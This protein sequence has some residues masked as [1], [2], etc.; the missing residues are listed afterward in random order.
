M[1]ETLTK[2]DVNSSDYNPYGV[3]H[4]LSD[5]PGE[6]SAFFLLKLCLKNLCLKTKTFA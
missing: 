4:C 6:R 1:W 5:L 3:G 2:W